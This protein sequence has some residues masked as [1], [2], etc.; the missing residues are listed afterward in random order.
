MLAHPGPGVVVAHI[1][2]LEAGLADEAIP[3]DFKNDL[4]SRLNE[5]N[6]Q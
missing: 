3:D 4:R 5:L 1:E 2:D 6:A